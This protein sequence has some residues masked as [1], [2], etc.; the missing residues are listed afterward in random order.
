VGII[1]D[2]VTVHPKLLGAQSYGTTD[3]TQLNARGINNP[4]D[5]FIT[6]GNEIMEASGTLRSR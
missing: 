3:W 6:V 4:R 2:R 1:V 5:L